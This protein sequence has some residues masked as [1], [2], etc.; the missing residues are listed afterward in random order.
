MITI[1]N[2]H[3]SVIDFKEWIHMTGVQKLREHVGEWMGFRVQIT[4]V[5]PNPEQVFTYRQINPI[6]NSTVTAPEA[7]EGLIYICSRI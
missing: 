5:I 1:I 4:C 7:K 3:E 2:D 6:S